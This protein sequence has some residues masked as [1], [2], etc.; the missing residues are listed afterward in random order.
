MTRKAEPW[1]SP[2]EILVRRV[3]K[4]DVTGGRVKHSSLRLQVSV[5]RLSMLVPFEEGAGHAEVSVA[6]VSALR[7]QDSTLRLV[8]LDEPVK[9]DDSHALIAFVTDCAEHDRLTP[10]RKEELTKVM[11]A[12]LAEALRITRTPTV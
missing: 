2:A 3:R 5:R 1:L 4:Q 11:Q 6:D 10:E 8:C 12:R 7:C 9:D